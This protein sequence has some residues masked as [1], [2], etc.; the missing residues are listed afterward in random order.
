MLQGLGINPETYTPELVV[1]VGRVV[2]CEGDAVVV[3]PVRGVSFS[4]PVDGPEETH[5]WDAIEHGEWRVIT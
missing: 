3:Q 2:L 1:T 4:G 5:T